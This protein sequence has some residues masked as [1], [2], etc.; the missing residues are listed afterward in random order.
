MIFGR[1]PARNVNVLAMP[2]TVLISPTR[3]EAYGLAA[4]EA[5]STGVPALVSRSAGVA[6]RYPADLAD[7]LLA[8]SDDSQDLIARLLGWRDRV[9]EYARLTLALSQ[10]LNQY[11]WDDMAAQI[12]SLL[13]HSR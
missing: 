5:L 7:L 9:S 11:T 2:E 12:V 4:Q 13:E 3:Y 6:E 1:L 8:D 10:R